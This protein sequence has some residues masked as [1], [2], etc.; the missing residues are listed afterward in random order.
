MGREAL[1]SPASTPAVDA[2]I[3]EAVIAAKDHVI[4]NPISKERIVIRKTSAETG[5]D[6]LEWELILAPGGRVPSSHVHPEQQERFTVVDG[7]M[8]FR[9]GGRKRTVGPGESVTVEPGSVHS[10]ANTGRIPAHVLVQT[11]PALDMEALLEM[12]AALAQEQHAA[13]RRVPR[14][15]DLMLFMA[16]FER[17]VRAPYLPV[18]LARAVTRPLA[19]LAGSHGRDARYRRL[20]HQSGRAEG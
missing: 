16:D 3:E 9:I 6:L 11:R 13:A 2:G 1:A 8:D 14:L 12:A 10:F 7:R 18:T 20:R 5:G 19:R 4:E 15:L 17:E